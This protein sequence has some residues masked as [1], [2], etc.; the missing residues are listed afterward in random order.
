M[1]EKHI[2]KISKFLSLILRHNPQKINLTLDA[3]GWA[4]IDDII[5]NSKHLTLTKELILLVVERN[6]KKRFALNDDHTKIRASQGHSI[7]IELGL[8]AKEPPEILYHGTA[9]RFVDSIKQQGLIKKNRQHVHLSS[10]KNTAVN[11]GQRYGKPQ[12]LVINTKAM[13]QDGIEFY[14]S[15]NNVWLVDSV[16]VKYISF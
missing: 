8:A 7:A 10:N 5:A 14:L 1:N 11:V 3:N 9:E 13:R 12:V 4:N 16:A 6:D 15:E 2:I